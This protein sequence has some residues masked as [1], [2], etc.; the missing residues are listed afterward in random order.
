MN[1]DHNHV[2]HGYVEHNHVEHNPLWLHEHL[3]MVI[4]ADIGTDAQ[5]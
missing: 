5:K 2:Q 3:I 1:V 4:R